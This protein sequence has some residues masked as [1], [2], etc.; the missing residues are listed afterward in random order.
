MLDANGEGKPS[1]EKKYESVIV[2]QD[3]QAISYL[4]SSGY[5][6]TAI[7]DFQTGKLVAFASNEKELMVQHGTFE[8]GDSANTRKREQ[9]TKASHPQ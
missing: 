8:T 7:L 5:T 2:G 1:K 6:L 9:G 3:V 4:G